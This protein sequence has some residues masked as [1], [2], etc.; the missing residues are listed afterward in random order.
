M[1]D[2]SRNKNIKYLSHNENLG[3]SSAIYTGIKNSKFDNI[4]TID[5]D[6]QNNPKD[7]IKLLEVYEK[8]MHDLVAGIRNNRIDSYILKL[9]LRELQIK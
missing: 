7:I 4:I 8:D 1:K 2:I 9:Y 6:G 3:Q 5:A